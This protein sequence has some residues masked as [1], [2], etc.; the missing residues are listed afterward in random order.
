MEWLITIRWIVGI[1]ALLFAAACALTNYAIIYQWYR[2][3]RRASMIW[4]AGSIAGVI[5]CLLT[6]IDGLRVWWWI[7]LIVD[8]G[9]VGFLMIGYVVHVLRGRRG[10]PEAPGEIA[11]HDESNR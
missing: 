6:P 8:P 7:P 10:P 2:H 9:S 11:G 5:G 4:A 3:R 1:L